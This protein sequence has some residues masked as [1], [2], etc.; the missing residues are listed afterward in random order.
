MSASSDNNAHL[1]LLVDGTM[2]RIKPDTHPA[3]A[4]VVQTKREDYRR[5]YSPN[6]LAWVNPLDSKNLPQLL[7]SLKIQTSHYNLELTH[8]STNPSDAPQFSGFLDEAISSARHLKEQKDAAKRSGMQTA[9]GKLDDF[10]NPKH[11]QGPPP[12]SI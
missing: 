8:T 1:I 9:V 6:A 10:L 2:L 4:E 3:L 5:K 11:H 7:A 12:P